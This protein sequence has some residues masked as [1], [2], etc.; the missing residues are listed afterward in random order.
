MS[1]NAGTPPGTAV[2]AQARV[3]VDGNWT[4][5]SSFGRWSPYLERE[6]AAPV[7]KGAVNLL[8][9]SLVL[10]SKTAT[11]AQL[12]IYLYTKDEHTTPSVSLVGVSVRAVD[13][14]PAGG[15]PSTHACT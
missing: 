14:I 12:R 3:M 4:S 5:W 1:W 11:Q 9:D 10:D 7:T 13:V 2:E 15:R 8:P 6:G